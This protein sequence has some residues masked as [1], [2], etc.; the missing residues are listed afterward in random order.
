[1]KL[2]TVLS[3]A[4]A[5][6]YLCHSTS[7]QSVR[8]KDHSDW[9]SI[10]NE[11]SRR[12]NIKQSGLDLGSRNF[13]IVKLD[14]ATVGF[15][16]IQR[17]LGRTVRISRGDGS[18]GREQACYKSPVER[19]PVFLIFEF[20]EDQSSFYLFADGAP[21]KGQSFCTRSKRVSEVLSTDS[22]LHLGITSEE[23]KMILG[24]PDAIVGDKMM[25]SR[26]VKRKSA[27]ER[28]ERQRKEYPEA[29]SDAQA[30]N[31]FDF[32]TASLYIEAKFTNSKLTY[33]VVSTSG[34]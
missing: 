1:M 3:I 21:W 5:S 10:L 6:L 15:N 7:A 11:D 20:G 31:K 30:H 24:K 4:I 12:P 28:F 8:M 16:D 22:G 32:Y 33:I 29:L 9:W 25:Y 27:L 13:K 18:T 2:Q 14:L 17:E 34:Q 23:L 26:A 19:A